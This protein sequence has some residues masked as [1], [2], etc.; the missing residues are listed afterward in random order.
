[1]M[2][3][4]A[5]KQSATCE[6]SSHVQ[7]MDKWAYPLTN[8]C[9]CGNGQEPR[10]CATVKDANGV[11][12]LHFNSVPWRSP[13]D[14]T[15]MATEFCLRMNAQGKQSVTDCN[16]QKD[17]RKICS[18]CQEG[19]PPKDCE[20]Y[21]EPDG[22]NAR[23]R[24][25]HPTCKESSQVGNAAKMR[26]ALEAVVK[27]GYPHNFQREAPHIRGY[28]YEITTAIEKCFAAL[29]AP[30]RNCDRF[31]NADEAKKAIHGQYPLHIRPQDERDAV[32][33]WLFAE[34]KGE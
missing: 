30:P 4:F 18:A 16:Q 8:V 10:P 26:E 9:K 22:C 24:C 14:S 23:P 3:N 31:D 25:I 17:W 20:F 19:K 21:G 6:K 12:L 7:P 33:D 28:C 15:A 13:K 5:S 2:P 29:S 32:I 27:V 11:V 34:A 1:M